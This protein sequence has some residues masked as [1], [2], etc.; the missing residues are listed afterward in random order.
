[1]FDALPAAHHVLLAH[2]KAVHA[3]RAVGAKQ[4]GCANNHAP[5]WPENDTPEALA[6][7]GVFDDLWNNLFADPM[8]TGEYPTGFAE[9]MPAAKGGSVTDDLAVIGA[10]LDFYGV[11]YYN[12]FLVGAAPEGAEM[13]FEYR[14]IEGCP[15][16]DF[17]WPVVPDGLRE[18]L[19]HL[20]DRYPN[21]PP[22]VIT[23][24]GC[25]YNMEPD[26]AG[27]VDDQPRIDYLDSHL[28][29][30]G[31]AIA[32]GVDVA[33][34]YTWSL[35]DNFEWSEGYS[36]RFGLVHVDYDTQVRTPK[37]SYDW[38]RS[39]IAASRP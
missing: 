32:E 24:S 5:M 17:G 23:E 12:P 33:G 14:D 9:Q 21:L 34:Y 10:P 29:A 38:F 35:M 26:A 39:V 19:V 7:T 25:A 28:R 4:I 2:G 8:L 16:T 13:P 31:D 3:L 20:R 36:Q 22:V 18:Q 30:V 1:M 11:N 27:V 6:A 15:K 37:R